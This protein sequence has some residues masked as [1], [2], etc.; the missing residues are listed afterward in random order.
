MYLNHRKAH[1]NM[2]RTFHIAALTLLIFATGMLA[3]CGGNDQQANKNRG[4]DNPAATPTPNPTPGKKSLGDT[5]IVVS[6]GSTDLEFD[7]RDIAPV[8][9][10][11]NKFSTASAAMIQSVVLNDDHESKGDNDMAEFVIPSSGKCTINLKYRDGGDKFVTVSN[12]T[13]DGKLEVTFDTGKLKPRPHTPSDK[14]RKHFGRKIK[15][16]SIEVTSGGNAVVCKDYQGIG[17]PPT[18]PICKLPSNGKFTLEIW[19]Q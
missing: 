12:E 5:P 2:R 7:H 19:L 3:G 1:E 11:N 14:V 10:N 17:H 15:L 6:G 8:T 16:D 18:D 4:L 13:A 9:G